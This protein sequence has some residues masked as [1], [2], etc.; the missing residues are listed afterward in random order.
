[1]DTKQHINLIESIKK[2]GDKKKKKAEDKPVYTHK[3]NV[4]D[5]KKVKSTS[6]HMGRLTDSV[7]HLD[8][9]DRTELKNRLGAAVARVTH[10]DKKHTPKTNKQ[11][12]LLRKLEREEKKETQESVELG[13]LYD[14]TIKSY[15]KKSKEDIQPI[16]DKEV[17]FQAGSGTKPY[18]KQVARKERRE[19]GIKKGENRLATGGQEKTNEDNVLAKHWKKIH[20]SR[21]REE[22]EKKDD[23]KKSAKENKSAK[24]NVDDVM[25][26]VRKIKKRE[27]DTGSFE[28]SVEADFKP[29]MMYDPKTG[30]GYKADTYKDHVRMDKMGYTHDKP[31]LDE[32]TKEENKSEPKKIKKIKKKD[33]L[34]RLNQYYPYPTHSHDKD[35]NPYPRYQKDHV[36]EATKAEKKKR[37]L[38]NRTAVA[39][40]KQ[41]T[42]LEP[43]E[44]TA[45]YNRLA[46]TLDKLKQSLK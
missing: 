11:A 35:G 3:P 41:K 27:F 20:A 12:K 19:A 39:Y 32:A 18:K 7:E 36:E 8:E 21:A 5:E 38:Q 16:K 22:Q 9:I 37:Q 13:E 25:D 42:E 34:P 28:E 31:E 40:S 6:H 1:M 24:I 2:V 17:A 30:K 43:G 10:S 26:R 15:I 45:K 23:E 4:P 14:T 46:D 44:K 29:H 33:H